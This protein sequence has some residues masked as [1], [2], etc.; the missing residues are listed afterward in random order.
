ML[1]DGGGDWDVCH[2]NEIDAIMNNI[3]GVSIA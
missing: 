2:D 1:N 3:N